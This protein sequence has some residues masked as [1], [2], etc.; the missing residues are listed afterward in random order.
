MASGPPPPDHRSSI[1]DTPSLDT[2]RKI[3]DRLREVER[4]IAEELRFI[5]AAVDALK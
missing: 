5:A 1:P 2:P 3:A 4:Y